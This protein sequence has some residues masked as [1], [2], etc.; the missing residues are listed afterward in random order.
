MFADILNQV[1][2]TEMKI[3]REAAKADPL[4]H[5][6]SPIFEHGKLR[7][8]YYA[9]KPTKTRE[10]RYCWTTYPNVAGFYLTWRET[11]TETRV[12]RDKHSSRRIRKAAKALAYSRY[13]AHK[14]RIAP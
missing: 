3:E 14:E 11:E 2:R 1:H 7:Y 10:V 9:V 4:G 5:K 12:T 13:V 8:R 6:L